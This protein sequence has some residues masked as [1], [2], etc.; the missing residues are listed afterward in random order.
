MILDQREEKLIRRDNWVVVE[1]ELRDH[2][3]MINNCNTTIIMAPLTRAK[4]LVGR[5]STHLDPFI[6]HIGL[7]GEVAQQVDELGGLPP[8]AG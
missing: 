2:K 6:V 5:G 3:D 7:H 4:A 1:F 8:V